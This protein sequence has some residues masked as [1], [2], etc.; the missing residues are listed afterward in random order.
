MNR[1]EEVLQE[2]ARL[3]TAKSG[4]TAQMLSE[5]LQV[6]RS[7]ISRIL[8]QLAEEG[9]CRKKKSR[10]VLFF[11]LESTEKN[12]ARKSKPSVSQEATKFDLFEAENP[13]LSK[14]IEQGKAAILYPPHGM[15]TLILGK[16]GVGKS[17]FAR[18]LYTFGQ[19]CGHLPSAAPLI[20]FNCADYANNPQLLLTNLFGVEKGA[21]TGAETEKPGLLAQADG[22]ILFLDEIHRLPPEGQEMLFTFIDRGVYK[23]LGAV[24]EATAQVMLIGATTEKKEV[25]LSTML[26]RM[27]M[28]IDIPTLGERSLEE[29]LMLFDRLVMSEVN[30]LN[31]PVRFSLNAIKSFL[32]YTCAGNVGQFK[33]DI[34]VVLAKAYAKYLTAAQK[35][36]QMHLATADLPE[37][38]QQGLLNTQI[39]RQLWR[40][41]EELATD[42]YTYLPAEEG[43]AKALSDNVYTRLA[44]TFQ[45]LEEQNVSF[46]QIQREMETDLFR[47]FERYPERRLLESDLLALI[48]QEELQ[49]IRQLIALAETK[50]ARRFSDKCQHAIAIHLFNL[51]EQ[52]KAGSYWAR[53][54]RDQGNSLQLEHPHIWQV[55]QQ[56]QKQLTE[57]YQIT[58]PTNET[59]YLGMLFCYDELSQKTQEQVEIIVI[60]HGTHTASSMSQAANELLCEPCTIGLDAALDQTPQ[61]ILD[62][63]RHYLSAKEEQQDLLLLV[64]MGSLTNFAPVIQEEFGIQ[65]KAIPLVSTMHV[66]EAGRKSLLHYSLDEIYRDTLK[67]QEYQQLIQEKQAP[68]EKPLAVIALCL[69]GKGTALTIKEVLH[70]QL[71][72]GQQGIEVIPVNLAG[73]GTANYRIHKIQET[74]QV[75]CVVSSL[76]I[77]VDLPTFDFFELIAL[78]DFTQLQRV[79]GE[80]VIYRDMLET[81]QSYYGELPLAEVIPLIYRFNEEVQACL[82]QPFNTSELTG[83]A[84]HILGML[85]KDRRQEVFPPFE[86]EAGIIANH[87][88]FVSQI[89][90]T[91]Q[92]FF[93]TFFRHLDD[94][95]MNYVAYAYLRKAAQ[96]ELVYQ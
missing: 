20:E 54:D 38:I 22:G 14:Q 41:F 94:N 27:P 25:L 79:V 76:P 17:L 53:E 50:L 59:A 1:I 93:G 82:D 68:K 10:P 71:Q 55:A 70:K 40:Y 12:T 7:N 23:P 83:L 6:E 48:P 24:K 8:N 34:C 80:A 44:T 75:I 13:S 78:K 5:V 42:H 67:I 74:Y 39:H 29:R 62:E 51:I 72:L 77:Q 30:K 26:R 19:E 3:G 11:P 31:L 81:A 73:K 37:H 32:G 89:K 84:F 58:L 90:T 21:Y 96:T 33:A 36:Q 46:A 35:P 16:T 60:A 63:L 69:S 9:R 57:R 15:H 95:Q 91:F 92:Q 45:D 56:C 47:Y 64:D 28:V 65:V 61:E 2:L 87:P 66:I 18:L 52:I 4:V 43:R 49:Q 88:L 86:D 85:L